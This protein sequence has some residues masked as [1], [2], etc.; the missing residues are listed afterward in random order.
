M[1]L[2][3]G[4]MFES[5]LAPG[6]SWAKV[7]YYLFHICKFLLSHIGLVTLVVSYCILGAFIFEFLEHDYETVIKKNMTDTRLSITGDLWEMTE[8]MKL[9]N[10]TNWTMTVRDKLKNFEILIVTAMK[11]DGWDGSES[12]EKRNWT[13]SGSLFY[14]IVV[15]TTIGKLIYVIVI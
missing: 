2:L 11:K 14:S 12:L 1:N 6:F 4:A 3:L 10:K 13:F 7:R 9:L 5:D 8:K 15:I